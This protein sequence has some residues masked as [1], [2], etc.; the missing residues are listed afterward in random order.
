MQL[1][2]A[3]ISNHMM[4]RCSRNKGFVIHAIKYANV[5]RN[6][7]TAKGQ[8][9]PRVQMLT[10][11]KPD[12]SRLRVFGCDAYAL[13]EKEARIHLAPGTTSVKGVFV[14]VEGSK[15]L[16]FANSRVWETQH[17]YFYES[18]YIVKGIPPSKLMV[19][20]STQTVDTKVSDNTP[21]DMSAS[22]KGANKVY[23]RNDGGAGRAATRSSKPVHASLMTLSQ[24]WERSVQGLPV[25]MHHMWPQ[26]Y[27]THAYG[28][29]TSKVHRARGGRHRAIDVY[30]SYSS[31]LIYAPDGMQFTDEVG[32][33]DDNPLQSVYAIRL[34]S[35]PTITLEGPQGT[36]SMPNPSTWAQKPKSHH[37]RVNG[38]RPSV[39]TL[40]YL[41][42]MDSK[43]YRSRGPSRR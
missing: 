24:A 7:K 34:E 23:A 30:P 3:R 9:L 42:V 6:M 37:R 40:R 21:H 29:G 19:H 16:V 14:G 2:L 17:V 27:A 10:G 13:I 4:Q 8:A 28:E 39:A 12:A 31:M 26:V 11:Q 36:Y 38:N 18:P 22:S 15:W 33:A 25:D 5:M 43:W 20:A 41:S 35:I 32:P 1:D